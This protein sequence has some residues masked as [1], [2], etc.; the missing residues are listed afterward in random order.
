[1]GEILVIAVIA[2]LVFGPD[3]LPE[4]A[5]KSA[6]A[7]ARFRREATKSVTELKKAA[8]MDD[9]D[10]EL[11]EIRSDVRRVGRDLAGLGTGERT[12]TPA[13]SNGAPPIDP[14]AT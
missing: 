5:Q 1:M 11:R 3:R 14:D 12:T 13:P 2:L 4:L 9:L 8:A 10:R 7:L 6:K